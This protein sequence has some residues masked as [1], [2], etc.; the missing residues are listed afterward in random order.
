MFLRR[1]FVE[2]LDDLTRLIV[3]FNQGKICLCV[4]FSFFVSELYLDYGIFS[5]DMIFIVSCYT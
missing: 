5:L 2:N 3:V 1:I 4:S